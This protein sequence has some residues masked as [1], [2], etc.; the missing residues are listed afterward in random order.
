KTKSYR[1]KCNVIAHSYQKEVI[2]RMKRKATIMDEQKNIFQSL[3]QDLT[4]SMNIDIERIL[5]VYLK[6]T[7]SLECIYIL[8]ENGIQTTDTVFNRNI[9]IKNE[10]MF[11]PTQSGDYHISKQY[12]Y[13]VITNTDK[14]YISSKYVSQ[15]TG[16]LCR[17]ISS[18]FVNKEGK[19][20]VCVDFSAEK[21]R[22]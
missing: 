19:K 2:S 6:K 18:L 11:S 15:A 14:I 9:K 10:K 8:D 3:V 16:N 17:T 1:E 5:S 22:E 21:N 4:S 12:Y 7:P 13:Y 20:I